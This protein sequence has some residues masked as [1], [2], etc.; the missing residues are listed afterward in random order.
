MRTS[1][2]SSS[3]LRLIQDVLPLVEQE[4]GAR[5]VQ[6]VLGRRRELS[7][8]RFPVLYRQLHHLISFSLLF[9]LGRSCCI[10]VEGGLRQRGLELL[11]V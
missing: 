7:A 9:N 5:S 6:L 10:A 3:L 4:H 11:L 2:N 1:G 8:L